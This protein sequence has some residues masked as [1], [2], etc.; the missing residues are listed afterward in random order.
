MRAWTGCAVSYRKG[1]A[2]Q[3]CPNGYSSIVDEA[4]CQVAASYLGFTSPVVSRAETNDRPHGCYQFYQF[5]PGGTGAFIAIFNTNTGGR[6]L[7]IFGNVLWT[8]YG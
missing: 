5:N 1:D 4:A 3:A 6:A 8:D 2:G 7:Q